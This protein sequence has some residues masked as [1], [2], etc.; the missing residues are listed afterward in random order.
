MRCFISAHVAL[1]N[2]TNEVSYLAAFITRCKYRRQ[3]VGFRLFQKAMELAQH[4]RIVLDSVPSIASTY[5]KRGFC[6]QFNFCKMKGALA[7]CSESSA[8]SLQDIPKV[9]IK[10]AAEVN[11]LRICQYDRKISGTDRELFIQKFLLKS[12]TQATCT[13]TTQNVVVGLLVLHKVDSGHAT[14]SPFMQKI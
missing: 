9:F 3:G 7:P 11:M 8:P 14:Y 1:F 5:E 13:I 12:T 6:K 4:R 2:S 10:P